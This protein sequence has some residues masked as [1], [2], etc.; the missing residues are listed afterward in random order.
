M[1]KHIPLLYYF[2][3]LIVFLQTNL[4]VIGQN[5][6]LFHPQYTD[7]EEIQINTLIDSCDSISLLDAGFIY[8]LSIDGTIFQPQE[9]S[10]VRIVLEDIVGHDY[11]VVESD[12]FRNDTTIME[13]DNYCEETVD[14]GGIVPKNLK[15]YLS[16]GSSIQIE[17]INISITPKTNLLRGLSNNTRDVRR[18]QVD[19]IVERI[20]NYNK[21]H[22]K[23]WRAGVT[24]LSLMEYDK[25]NRLY[26]FSDTGAYD[27]YLSNYI[28]YKSGIYEVGERKAQKHR[29]Q[30]LYTP[31]FR[32]DRIHGQNWMTIPKNQWDSNWCVCFATCSVLEALVNLQYNQHID[33]DLS[34]ADIA[35]NND[36]QGYF[37]GA[38]LVDGLSVARRVGVIDEAAYPFIPDS[39]QI[40]PLQR[41]E[42][43]ELIGISSYAI[44]SPSTSGTD[45]VKNILIHKG[46]CVSGYSGHAM[47]L[48]GYDK[49]TE[50]DIYIVYDSIGRIEGTDYEDLLGEEY[51][52]F[53]DSYYE[54]P[55]PY[56]QTIYGEHP[57]YQH[58][59]FHDLDKF[60]LLCYITGKLSSSN[61]SD[62]NIIWEDCD[63]DGFFNWGIGTI[64][65]TC[66]LWV[67]DQ[68]DGDDSD[69]TQGPRNMYGYNEFIVPDSTI[70]IEQDEEYASN[71]RHILQN[72]CIQ[73]NSTLIVSCEILMTRLAEIR[74]K[75]GSTLIV[76]GCIRNANLKMEPGSTLIIDNGGKIITHKL[77]DFT[78]PLG[79]R[80]QMNN[81]YIE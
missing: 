50:D 5:K 43:N 38:S 61:Y 8:S 57:G 22:C 62:E 80:F 1:K 44:M 19:N 30:S 10:F 60:P 3:S 4:P 27:S 73:N 24:P 40:W 32:W 13:L 75:P 53:K 45:L 9:K 81:G 63:G 67:P 78:I 48:V 35:Y 28:Y 59:V 16:G 14:L 54:H 17:K 36:R 11:L 77:D 42:G 23:L 79:V 58:I 71:S 29:N 15:C 56:F 72:I 65:V 31:T 20:N 2:I 33:L 6:I 64:P 51:W 68:P 34:E 12:W 55:D 52:I 18:A 37:D 76:E 7:V 26:G 46:P 21:R 66:P 74:V 47:A 41:P 25:R 69:A 39:M 70:Y 49:V